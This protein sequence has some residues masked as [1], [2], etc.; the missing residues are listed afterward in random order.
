M[1]TL[2]ASN[3]R[4]TAF[5]RVHGAGV[6]GRR[7]RSTRAPILFALGAVAHEMLTNRSLFA[8]RDDRDTLDR[9]W[10]LPDPAAVQLEP[11]GVARSRRHRAG[12]ALARSDVSLAERGGAARRAAHR[13]G[14]PRHR[15][16]GRARPD[17]A[18]AHVRRTDRNS[19][20]ADAVPG[21]EVWVD[22]TGVETRI[23]P[24]DPRFLELAQVEVR[25]PAPAAAPAPAPIA[26][27]PPPPAVARPVHVFEPELGPEPTQI[28]AMP[29]I[30][31]GN[32][33]LVS[34]VGETAP[35][36]STPTLPPPV[37]TFMESAD[38]GHASARR[39]QRM[40]IITVIAMVAIFVIAALV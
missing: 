33:P 6:R 28:G 16:P 14:A 3:A 8:G 30:S 35:R 1:A 36:T 27:E 18:R 21:A 9:V 37:A 29:L 25:S 39:I 10:G 34:L 26:P 15:D 23:Q 32:T 24:V 13:R 7:A 11:A 2:V 38:Q 17:L 5:V 40:A 4:S 31:F 22:D 12:G 20:P 19:P